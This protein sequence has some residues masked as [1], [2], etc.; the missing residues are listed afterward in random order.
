LVLMWRGETDGSR[1]FLVASRELP[2]L[3]MRVLEYLG[4]NPTNILLS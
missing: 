4:L 3:V 1:H 2:M